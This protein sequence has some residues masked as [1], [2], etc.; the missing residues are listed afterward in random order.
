MRQNGETRQ[1]APGISIKGWWYAPDATTPAPEFL[2]FHRC[3]FFQTVGRISDDS[4]DAIG[5]A[6]FQPVKTVGL[7]E[8][9]RLFL[10]RLYTLFLLRDS[11]CCTDGFTRSTGRTILSERLS[12]EGRGVFRMM[13]E[14][15]PHVIG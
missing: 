8:F 14:N 9:I 4:M 5:S 3:V 1:W 13:I 12:K 7:N 11:L 15:L 6:V 2:L 10:K